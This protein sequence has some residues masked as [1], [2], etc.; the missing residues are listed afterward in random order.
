MVKINNII[1]NYPKYLI[2]PVHSTNKTVIDAVPLLHG[3]NQI[4]SLHKYILTLTVFVRVRPIRYRY[5]CS[6]KANCKLIG[7]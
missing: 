1:D 2:L 3:Y 4:C 6:D 7:Q 5:D